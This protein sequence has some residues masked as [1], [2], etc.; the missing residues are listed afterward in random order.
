ME[1]FLAAQ[2]PQIAVLAE[3]RLKRKRIVRRIGRPYA[4]GNAAAIR[5]GKRRAAV[6]ADIK[7]LG[8][9]IDGVEIVRI[10]AIGERPRAGGKA[11]DGCPSRAA[12][13]RDDWLLRQHH[14]R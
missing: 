13:A 7:T 5:R 11:L 8:A 4:G 12:I 6:G 9:E 1:K 14:K 2:N 3:R 10:D